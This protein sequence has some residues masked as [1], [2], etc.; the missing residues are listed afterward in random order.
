MCKFGLIR[1][2]AK[3]HSWHW[4]QRQWPRQKSSK[5]EEIKVQHPNSMRFMT[6]KE[7]L[8]STFASSHGRG[9]A[10]VFGGTHAS[11][12]VAHGVT[13]AD[14][15]R[16]KYLV[17]I[18]SASIPEHLSPLLLPRRRLHRREDNE[19]LW[20]NSAH[21]NGRSARE[22]EIWKRAYSVCPVYQGSVR[23]D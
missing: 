16:L 15:T 2:K 13:R 12:Q 9:S 6:P 19:C 21:L 18:V 1:A 17:R 23:S 22:S 20:S 8:D 10:F 14:A 11:S 7:M 4:R 5:G 3:G